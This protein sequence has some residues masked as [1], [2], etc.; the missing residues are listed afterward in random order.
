MRRSSAD[1]F[2]RGGQTTQH[3]V[4]M[5]AQVL[6]G[7]LMFAGGVF[8]VVWVILAATYYKVENLHLMYAHFQ[9]KF[10]VD[11]RGT[12]DHQIRYLHPTRG[13]I[14][15]DAGSI[16]TNE[17]IV[18]VSNDYEQKSIDFV[19]AATLPAGFAAI[20]SFCFFYFS[21]RD[22]EGDKH[23][24]GTHL[25]THKELQKWSKTKW[26]N[27]ERQFGKDRKKGPRYTIAGIEFP[28]DAVEAQ[29]VIAGTVGVGK[30]NAIRELLNTVRE[31]EGKAIIYDRMGTF[32]EDFYNPEID[33]IINPY[34]CRSH[35]WSPF[36]EAEY[37]DFFTQLAEVFIPDQK[38]SQDP[39]WT[40]AA[41]IVFDYAA[42]KLFEEKNHSNKALREAI[43]NIP[44][45][46]LGEL[47]EQTPGAHF[48]SKDAMKTASSIRA[49]LI[50][51][52]R[53]LE[54]LRD[55]GPKFSMRDW[56]KDDKR[57]GFIFLTGDAEHEA[58]TRNIISSLCEVAANALMVSGQST[59]PK[60]WFFLDEVPTL[61]RLPFLS[62]S[63]AQIR[64][65]GGAFVIGYQ[66][67]SQLES[68]YGDKDAKTI[69]GNL[70]NRLI[71]NTP[72]ADT[73]ETF[74]KSLGSEDVE[75]SRESITVG[76][77]QS[78]DG[79][80]FNVSR[81]ERRIVTASQIQSLA[82]FQGYVSFA[83]DSP[84]AF[85]EFKPFV[86]E[87]PEGQQKQP[88]FIRYEGKGFARGSLGLLGGRKTHKDKDAHTVRRE[89]LGAREDTEE[90]FNAYR[91]RLL[92]NGAEYTR[93]DNNRD[94]IYAH[95]ISERAMGKKASDIGP[96]PLPD[97][98][99]PGSAQVATTQPEERDSQS[100][101]SCSNDN[102]PEKS[103]TVENAV[104]AGD[105]G[106]EAKVNRADDALASKVDVRAT[107]PKKNKPQKNQNSFSRFASFIDPHGDQQ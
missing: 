38:G 80:G 15:E 75:E 14:S 102:E 60:L 50:T 104:D 76:A 62:K 55:D 3:W 54:F 19:W 35:S 107:K 41:R 17:Y 53:F 61:N 89:Q 40:Q 30:S 79:V 48:F 84:T 83:Y 9:S 43:L 16:Y 100:S 28:P 22:L 13:W 91:E 65:F 67:F 51:E 34:D 10:A 42:R 82:Q 1:V 106:A 74:S 94:W 63:L 99:M 58:A 88:A 57:K 87:L 39:F 27:Y 8:V 29:T 5:G 6:K 25:V 95:F 71:F 47:I 90:E 97:D 66:V 26:R 52:L 12:P 37:A 31:V 85:V 45:E 78:R 105:S 18:G 101:P 32:V 33:I 2:I 23:V 73:A 36:Y 68:I 93:G 77:H 86:V 7:T 4:R 49:N 24:R 81:S 59:E 70:N 103:E 64:Q 20:F 46:D 44:S 21:G 11:N 56:V 96:P 98:A 69:S 72:D 92:K